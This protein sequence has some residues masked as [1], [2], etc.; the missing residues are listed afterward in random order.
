MIIPF[1]LHVVEKKIE[2]MVCD[3]Q[4]TGAKAGVF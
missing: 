4:H 3:L 2:R 1:A